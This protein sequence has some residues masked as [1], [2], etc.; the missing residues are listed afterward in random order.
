MLNQQIIDYIKKSLK[1]GFKGELIRDALEKAGWSK[2][3]IDEGFA[4]MKKKKPFRLPLL[5]F[6]SKK[7][8]LVILLIVVLGSV[9]FAG[10]IT[11]V[12]SLPGDLFLWLASPYGLLVLFPLIII[13]FVIKKKLYKNRWWKKGIF[14]GT[15]LYLSL[16][17]P[18]VIGGRWDFWRYWIS[19]RDILDILGGIFRFLIALLFI[20]FFGLAF[21]FFS[22]FHRKK[23]LRY[24]FG[25]VLIL[26]F[27]LFW[28]FFLIVFPGIG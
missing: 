5:S 28:F 23:R 21:L 7:K 12:F 26:L 19:G 4:S 20:L 18:N 13:F 22:L 2:Q 10:V 14:I 6:I 15:I 3:Q 17:L 9:V 25:G 1:D 11:A 8:F 16:S 27:S 24:L